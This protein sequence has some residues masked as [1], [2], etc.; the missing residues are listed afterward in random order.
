MSLEEEIGLVEMSP[1][2]MAYREPKAKN[3]KKYPK[4]IKHQNC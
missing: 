2:E 4:L 3:L 1:I